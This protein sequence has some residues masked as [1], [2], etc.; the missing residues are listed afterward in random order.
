MKKSVITLILTVVLGFNL[1]SQDISKEEWKKMS[2]KER[3]GYKEKV[4]IENRTRTLQIL[5]SQAWVLEANTLQDRYGETY[6][7]NPSL[8]FVGVAGDKSTIQLG[9]NGEIGLNGVG[10]ITLDGNVQ[11][12]ELTEGKKTNSPMSINL[13][14][15]GSSSGFVS[16]LVNVSPDGSASATVTDVQGNR[17]TYRGQIKAL[18]ESTVYKG[19]TNYL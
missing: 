16:I 3:K 4:L 7:L 2:P 9:E 17:L 19:I 6:I 18:G 8:N 13:Q 5:S 14:V 10:G 1:F 11:K 15:V 12:Y